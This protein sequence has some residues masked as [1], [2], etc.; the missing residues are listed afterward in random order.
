[1]S[2]IKVVPVVKNIEKP[3][4]NVLISIVGFNLGLNCVVRAECKKGDGLA[5]FIQTYVIEGDEYSNW[6]ND[7]NTSIGAGCFTCF[8]I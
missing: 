1:M 3:I 4:D 6:G 2:E 7:D 5:E 8:N